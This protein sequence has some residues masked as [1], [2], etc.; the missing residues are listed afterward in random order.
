MFAM[1]W[2]LA[3]CSVSQQPLISLF[4]LTKTHATSLSFNKSAC[5]T[6]PCDD[7]VMY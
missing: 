3:Y 2:F 1:T 4:H 5:S 6:R 7:H